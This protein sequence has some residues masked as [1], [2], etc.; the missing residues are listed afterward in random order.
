M[1]TDADIAARKAMTEQLELGH[2]CMGR[3]D[4]ISIHCGFPPSTNNCDV[5]MPVA[6]KEQ[7]ACGKVDATLM[8]QLERDL[9]SCFGPPLQEHFNASAECP[10]GPSMARNADLLPGLGTS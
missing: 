2:R 8:K 3:P 1:A 5:L 6:Y 7:I 4:L 10:S 9:V